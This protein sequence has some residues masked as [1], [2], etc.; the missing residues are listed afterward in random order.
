MEEDVALQRAHEEQRGGARVA[1]AQ[2]PGLGGAAEPIDDDG[3]AAARGRVALRVEGED[4]RVVLRDDDLRA[5]HGLGERHELLGHAAEDGA[6]VGVAGRGGELQDRGRR[7][8]ALA[9]AH[10]LAEERVL[11]VDMTEE[12][13]RGDAE[14]AGDVGQRGGG[15]AFGREDAAGGVEELIAAEA[16]R[17]AHL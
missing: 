12:R 2:P 5:D 8:D 9:A 13:R 17:A 16:R 1:H 6:R 15:E 7:V 14:L 3:E 11:R 10:R 4:E